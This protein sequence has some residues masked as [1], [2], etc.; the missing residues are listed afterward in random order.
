M[1]QFLHLFEE[2]TFSLHE[3]HH[4]KKLDAPSGT[5]LSMASWVEGTVD[6]SSER[7]GDVV[8]LHTLTM[9]TPREEITISHNALDRSLFAEGAIK[10]AQ[11][12]VDNKMTPGLYNF[13]EV[14]EKQL[15]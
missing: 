4:T 5:A 14:V 3:V 6:I 11:M 12:I 13:Q 8:G 15:S 7:T 1:N 10:A 2:K 9:K